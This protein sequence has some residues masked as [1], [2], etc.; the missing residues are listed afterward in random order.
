MWHICALASITQS[1]VLSIYRAQQ[2]QINQSSQVRS[3]LNV[4]GFPQIQ[5]TND[6]VCSIMWSRRGPRVG[7]FQ[8]NRFVSCLENLHEWFSDTTDNSPNFANVLS[9]ANSHLS[10]NE[11]FLNSKKTR[12][13]Q[14][15]QKEQLS[16]SCKWDKNHANYARKS[17]TNKNNEKR[18]KKNSY[19]RNKKKW[20]LRNK[21]HHV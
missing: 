14:A 13:L 1:C 15:Q 4:K 12:S 8:T 16:S 11:A 5:N 19:Y 7:L 9:N 21:K 3:V 2:V 20:N 10:C 18:E 17:E 6:N